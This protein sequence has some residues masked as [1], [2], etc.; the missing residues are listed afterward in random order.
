MK[1]DFRYS[2]IINLPG[3]GVDALQLPKLSF[4]GLTF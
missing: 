3:M 2:L 4:M 1:T